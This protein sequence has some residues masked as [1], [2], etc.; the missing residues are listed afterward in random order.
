MR[1]ADATR[2]SDKVY[3]QFLER[4]LKREMLPGQEFNRRQIA[5][6]M[7]VSVAPVLEA[8]LRLKEEGLIE[9]TPRR[10]TRVRTPTIVDL[11]GQLIVREALECEAARRYCGKPVATHLKQ[12]LR[13]AEKVD[14]ADVRQMSGWRDEIRF[15]RALIELLDLPPLLRA[16]DRVMK[17]GLFTT[18]HLLVP[19]S[20]SDAR[21][22]HVHLVEVLAKAGPDD[23]EQAMRFHHR[24]AK[25]SLLAELPDEQ[26][27][28]PTPSAAVPPWLA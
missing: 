8:M 20:V 17:L 1:M 11:R 28:V 22:S 12:L 13:L 2:L 14:R 4:L 10:G 27:R 15:H 26:T 16:F 21:D 7:G 19:T 5:A 6:E 3:Q 24:C 18:L 25:Q 23:A 9:S